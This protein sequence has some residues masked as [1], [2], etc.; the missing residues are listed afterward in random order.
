LDTAIEDR[1]AKLRQTFKNENFDALFILFEENRRYLSGFTGEDG[2][3][4]ESAGALFI[5]AHNCLLA[6]DSRYELQARMEAP[7]FETFCYREGLAKA[8]PEI[9]H[10]L[11]I[12][13]L[14]FESNRLSVGQ[15]KKIAEQFRSRN[16]TVELI[17][18]ENIVENLR[19]VKTNDEIDHTQEALA[20]AE[21]VFK[22]CMAEIKPGM[23]EKQVAWELE[24]GI[25][26]TG[27]D[28]LSFPIIVASGPNSALPHA[29]PGNRRIQKGEPILF[30]WGVKLNGYCSD[31]SRTVC[32][33]SPDNTFQTVFDTVLEAQQRAIDAVEPGMSAKRLDAVARDFIE[34][35]GFKGKFGHSLGHGTGLAIH[36]F[37]RIGPHY[38]Q[39]LT[40]GMVFTVEP[41]IY[42]SG[43]GGVRLENMVAVTEGGAKVLNK[44]DPLDFL[45]KG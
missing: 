29:I 2:Q 21:S 24:K 31:I 39:P 41:G 32:I 40:P 7:L 10:S 9:L 38:D 33:G 45:L 18:T 30:D 11:E 27:A 28:G 1:L 14:G 42:L 5:T 35:N 34:N 17:E 37:P 43:W 20:V 44:S 4:D 36:E 26:E 13:R 23:T 22:D 25:R 3:C 19:A 12:D 16:V 8:L 15:Y 6:T